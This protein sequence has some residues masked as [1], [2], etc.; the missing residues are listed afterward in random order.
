MDS[1]VDDFKNFRIELEVPLL[2]PI[3]FAIRNASV[4]D[5]RIRF[6]V[7]SYREDVIS[8]SNSKL[9][10]EN[11]EHSIIQNLILWWGI[12][13]TLD[14]SILEDTHGGKFDSIYI[15]KNTLIL[16][17]VSALRIL[18][19]KAFL[20]LKQDVTSFICTKQLFITLRVDVD[21]PSLFLDYEVFPSYRGTPNFLPSCNEI[22]LY[23]SK[24]KHR[25][26]TF[27]YLQLSLREV[28][29]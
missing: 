21:V 9:D 28:R 15:A 16:A 14:L 1:G 20:N 5:F 8:R 10:Y 24:G 17:V 22:T 19:K 29:F 25:K 3:F 4:H 23:F 11:S 2:P 27:N 7:S 6:R 13:T 12:K 26:R 18:F